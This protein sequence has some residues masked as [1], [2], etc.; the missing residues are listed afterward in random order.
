MYSLEIG[1]V[2]YLPASLTYVECG[3][4][5]PKEL[6]NLSFFLLLSLTAKQSRRKEKAQSTYT[7]RREKENTNTNF[8]SEKNTGK[9][10]KNV[11]KYYLVSYALVNTG[12]EL[13]IQVLHY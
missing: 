10:C 3:R 4:Q 8:Y 1:D 6:T 2:T 7:A 9:N 11:A 5:L 12:Q 13:S